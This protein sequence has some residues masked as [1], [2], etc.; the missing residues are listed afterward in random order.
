MKIK[1]EKVPVNTSN[2]N[3]EKKLKSDFQFFLSC[4]HHYLNLPA[5]T[6]IQLSICNYLQNGGKR[7]IIEAFRGVGKSHI[8]AAFAC[9]C[10]YREPQVKILVISATQ[11][12]ADAFSRFVKR[13]IGEIP[14]LSFLAPQSH[15]RNSNIEFDVAPAKNDQSPSVKSASITGQ[16][17]GSR[18]DIIIGDDLEIPRNSATETQRDKL[19]TLVGEFNAILKP[20]DDARIIYLGTPQ[21][22]NS[23][24]NKLA[25]RNYNIRIWT[26]RI[27]V[28]IN[29]Y[30]GRLAP[31]IHELIEQGGQ[32]NTTTEPSRF[33]DEDLLEREASYGRTGFQ[34]QFQLDTS[35][36]DALK[37]PLKLNDLMVTDLDESEAPIK[38]IWASQSQII[39]GLPNLGFDGDRYVKPMKVSDVWSPYSKIVMSIDN[40]GS[41]TDKTGYSVIAVLHGFLFVLDAGGIKGGYDTNTLTALANIAKRWNVH[42][43]IIERNFG[44]GMFTSL[45]KPVIHKI[46]QCHIDEVR[47]SVQKEKR[48]IDTLEPVMN[49]HKLIFNRSVIEKDYRDNEEDVKHSLMYQ[50]T[51]I[52]KDRG[53]LRHDDALDALAIAV[54]HHQGL[55]VIDEDIAEESF[56]LEKR[57]SQI[58]AFLRE[59]D[60][61]GMFRSDSHC[62]GS[63]YR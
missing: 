62:I 29:A 28:N 45:F 8:T 20:H 44:D 16:I 32:S 51:H 25:E 59:H 31:Y 47:H 40:S 22:Q 23:L 54:A 10:L 9:W 42:E 3:L 1:G 13:L 56:I 35:L 38:L 7:I 5:P 24:Y 17:T 33:S 58:D 36:S 11:G 41:G 60:E 49:R 4:L 15:Q 26:S 2:S 61:G 39:E 48:I 27:P 12:R 57:M 37:Y 63:Q 43:C 18:A 21:T 50:L 6:P 46:H 19:L 53:S 30:K 14:F 52:S 55:M 34:L